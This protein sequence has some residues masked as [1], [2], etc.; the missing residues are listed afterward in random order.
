[1]GTIF[2][3]SMASATDPIFMIQLINIL[4]N[5]YVVWDKEATIKFRK[6][7]NQSVFADFHFTQEEI[8]QIKKDVKMKNEIDILKKVS[9]TN[10]EGD[11]LFAEVNKTIYIADKNHY[12]E[13]RKRK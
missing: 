5:D 13:K 11:K 7:A 9:L 4:G 12:K 10:K 1:M 3:G 6:P 2:G 8:D